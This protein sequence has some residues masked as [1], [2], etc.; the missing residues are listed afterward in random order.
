MGKVKAT[1]HAVYNINYHLVWIAKYG[2]SILRGEMKE[3][4]KETFSEIAKQYEFEIEEMSVQRDHVHLFISAPPRY[5]PRRLADILEE[6]ILPKDDGR[7][8]Q[9]K[10]TPLAGKALGTRILCWNIRRQSY[11]RGDQK[12]YKILPASHRAVRAF[13]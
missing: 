7:V 2:K 11:R 3:R 8:A 1:A 12:V 10:T 9:A 4:V 13:C 6:Y 5:S